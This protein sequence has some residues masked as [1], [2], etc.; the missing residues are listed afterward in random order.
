[1][2]P[3]VRQRRPGRADEHAVTSLPA[4][5]AGRMASSEA[6]SPPPES[7]PDGV[8]AQ[9]LQIEDL[10]TVGGVTAVA[11]I[12]VERSERELAERFSPPI[13]AGPTGVVR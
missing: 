10:H 3:V 7:R 9:E 4:P 6:F 13:R 8:E 5:A 12:T 11:L 1:M 2:G